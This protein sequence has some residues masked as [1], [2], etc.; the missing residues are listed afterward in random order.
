MK[1]VVVELQDRHA[2]VLNEAGEYTRV[3]N[4]NYKIGQR[5][6]IKQK[7]C[8]A[9]MRAVA[10][11]TAI[12]LLFGG[13]V[14]AYAMPYT[15]VGVDINPSIEIKLNIFNQVIG[16][17]AVN[18]DAK[19]ILEH[20]S[21][22]GTDL[23]TAIARL[24]ERLKEAGYLNEDSEAEL[25]ITTYSQDGSRAEDALKQAEE[26]MERE[27][28]RV[29]VS[30]KVEGLCVRS[31]LREKAQEYGVSP[32]KLHLV[33]KYMATVE[34]PNSVDIAEWAN[35]S[36]KEIQSAI[37]ENRKQ[38]KKSEEKEDDVS[39]GDENTDGQ[40]Q[41]PDKG[42]NKNKPTPPG[43]TKKNSNN[44]K[45]GRNGNT[46]N[47]DENDDTD[48]DTEQTGENNDTESDTQTD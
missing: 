26:A 42:N 13:T 30:A 32:G 44:G 8:S 27:T 36:V 40:T 18:D 15:I 1:N 46:D 33:E 34:D 21:L 10:A 19:V 35:K 47:T 48:S 22:R 31:E 29:R 16:A 23:E 37:K 39:Q 28:E 17:D 2:V 9:A 11:L 7:R 5:V 38:Q 6:E 4:K 41:R 20:L 12:M 14:L 25:V 3:K 24:V 45:K 43:Q